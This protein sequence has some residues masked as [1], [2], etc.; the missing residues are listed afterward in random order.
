MKASRSLSIGS[1]LA[2]VLCINACSEPPQLHRHSVFVFGTLLE[3]SIAG[4]SA[5]EAEIAFF[6]LERMLLD[7]H[8]D[9]TPW[10][11]DSDLSRVNRAIRDGA[12]FDMPQSLEDMTR[13]SLEYH[14]LSDGLFDPAIGG[15]IKLWQFHRHE[16]PTLMPPTPSSIARWLQQAPSMSDLQPMA[17]KWRSDNPRVDLNFGA[18]AKGVAVAESLEWLRLRGFSDAL[19]NAGGDLAVIGQNVAATPPRPWSIGIRHPRQPGMLASIQVHSDEAVFTSGDY[20]RA[21]TRDGVYYH[22]ILDPRTGY[23]TQDT[24]SVTVIHSDAAR[25]DAAA[26]ALMVAGPD[27][28]Q[29]IARRFGLRYVMLV[30][31]GGEVHMTPAMQRRVRFEVQPEPP[32]VLSDDLYSD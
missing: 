3:I 7:R 5:S 32:I 26:T 31:T 29:R 12:S 15:L 22:H 2:A 4:G 24:S 13:R 27:E 8:A 9:W 11:P 1:L 19:I 14:A 6:D 20:E 21:Y 23:P 17:G 16:D 28:W 25:A 18:Y 30:D 10:E